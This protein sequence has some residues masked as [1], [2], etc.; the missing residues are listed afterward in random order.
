MVGVQKHKRLE[1]EGFRERKELSLD[2]RNRK[3]Q[4]MEEQLYLCLGNWFHGSGV[5]SVRERERV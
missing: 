4:V 1:R 2:K 5:L 3:M